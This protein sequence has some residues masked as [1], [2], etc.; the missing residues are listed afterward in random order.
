MPNPTVNPLYIRAIT[1]HWHLEGIVLFL[2]SDTVP[3]G[4]QCQQVLLSLSLQCP[5]QS[6][7]TKK[8]CEPPLLVGPDP[9]APSPSSHSLA[10]EEDTT[11]GCPGVRRGFFF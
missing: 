11:D 5:V 3:K 4:G 7:K 10:P 9:A 1:H 2:S 6:G 8:T